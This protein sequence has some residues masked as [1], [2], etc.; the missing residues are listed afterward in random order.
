MLVHVI[1]CSE[2]KWLR[3]KKM[4]EEEN[5]ELSKGQSLLANF[6]NRQEMRRWVCRAE[7][8]E[9]EGGQYHHEIDMLSNY[10]NGTAK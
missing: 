8:K 1:I 2:L 5:S 6:E 3:F 10:C 4:P 7:N 9:Q